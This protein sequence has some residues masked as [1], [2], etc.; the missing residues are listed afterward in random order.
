MY[1]WEHV[2]NWQKEGRGF[3]FS[4]NL[5][6]QDCWFHSACLCWTTIW[7]SLFHWPLQ[8]DCLWSKISRI[9]DIRLTTS[10][11]QRILFQSFLCCERVRVWCVKGMYF[12]LH[13]EWQGD[14]V[15]YSMSSAVHGTTAEILGPVHLLEPPCSWALTF[16]PVQKELARYRAS[17]YTCSS[18][19]FTVQ[20]SSKLT[21]TVVIVV[22]LY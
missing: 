14:E 22:I 17:V 15:P 9:Y 2:L 20:L 11:R 21:T 19:S 4:S 1:T 18:P 12:S 5:K 3:I 10:W 7:L 6:I 13:Q 16:W 8:A